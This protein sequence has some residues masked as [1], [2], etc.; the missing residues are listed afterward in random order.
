MIPTNRSSVPA[1]A[2]LCLAA[3][4]A[5]PAVAVAQQDV[6]KQVSRMNK[7]AMEDY[8]SL[9]FDSARKTLI[10]AV[11]ILR[12]N[13][14][15]ETPIAAKTYI[16]LGIIYINGFKD[17]NR[18]VQQF[19]NALKIKP[20][21]KIDPT[22]ATPEL[23]E[24]FAAARKQAGGA[25][26]PAPGPKSGPPKTEPDKSEPPKSEPKSEPPPSSKTEPPK[27][28]PPK[29]EVEADPKGLTHNPVDEARPN[30]PILIKAQLGSETGAT[31]VYLFYRATGQ[32]DF[33]SLVM[34][35]GA[36]AEWS[37]YIPAEATTGR[38]LQYYLEA[39]DNRGRAMVGSGSA[40]NPYI[41]SISEKAPLAA[42]AT[43]I[44]VED[45][46]AA[47]RARRRA[48]EARRTKY[49]RWFIFVMPGFGFGYQPAG[50]STEVAWQFQ[51]ATGSEPARYIRQPVQTGGAAFAPFHLSLEVG[52]FVVKG[53]SLSAIARIQLL[54]GANAETQPLDAMGNPVM[55]AKTTKATGAFAGLLRLRY[56]FLE[57][58]A[59]PY[60]SMLL[61]GGQIRQFLDITGAQTEQQPLVDAYTAAQF[62]SGDAGVPKQKVCGDPTYCTDSI[63]LGYFFVGGGVGLWLQVWKYIALVVD[64][65]LLGAIGVGGGQS[66]LNVDLQ[67]GIG[68]T[69]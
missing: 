18:G 44:D 5:A 38:A 21:A 28:E 32:E 57:G 34:K 26:G 48:E 42:G 37:A 45:P 13:G 51:P 4:A 52:A 16:N 50:N 65:N 24:A 54:T 47:E 30:T 33:V 66:G 15:D 6:E 10:D 56:R 17:R 49:Q 20:D 53:F 35:R 22:I 60:V 59:R 58:I 27:S 1:A 62:N 46:G 63:A 69:F 7:K 2:F 29:P 40:L 3:V 12:A 43:E 25:K 68:A 39:R 64:A 31:K 67:V 23:D 11:S 19:V 55:G 61:G 14:Y 36:G 9:E 8:D 41:V